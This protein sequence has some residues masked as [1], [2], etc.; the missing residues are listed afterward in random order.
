MIRL[1]EKQMPIRNSKFA[2]AVVLALVAYASLAAEMP[3]WANE[4]EQARI[5]L[6]YS[7]SLVIC[8]LCFVIGVYHLILGSDKKGER[9]SLIYG[10]SSILLAAYFAD[11]SLGHVIRIPL[12]VTGIAKSLLSCSMCLIL[13]FFLKHYE[14]R[15]PKAFI[16][17][18]PVACALAIVMMIANSSSMA[19]I[20]EYFTYSL[21]IVLGCIVWMVKIIAAQLRRGSR[22]ALPVSIGVLVGI[23]TGVH[24][25]IYQ[26]QGL[27]PALWLQG[28]GFFALYL[29]MFVGLA[30]ESVIMR[31]NLEEYSFEAESKRA[32]I[33]K[34]LIEMQ[35]IA[36]KAGR[37]GK[38][39]DEEISRVA[40]SAGRLNSSANAMRQSASAQTGAAEG[41]R[42]ELVKLLASF[43]QVFEGLGLQF[44]KIDET[45]ETIVR[46]LATVDDIDEALGRT[47]EISERLDADMEEGK[48][49]VEE[50]S[51]TIADMKG[52]SEETGEIA[53]TVSDFAKQTD[54]LAM[55][56]AIEAAH[57]GEAG[58]G[59]AVISDEIKRLA[60]AS[61]EKAAQIAV[62][63]A[64]IV[65]KI[66]QG[67]ATNSLVERSLLRSVEGARESLER[68]EA[69]AQAV[70]AQKE[71]SE[72]VM[73]YLKE[74]NEACEL[75]KAAAR[76]QKE[77]SGSM[78]GAVETIS[79]FLAAS[80]GDIER[81]GAE[82]EALFSSLRQLGSLAND[83]RS[84]TD[85]L[86]TLIKA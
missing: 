81:L 51:R 21:L 40:D 15:V 20:E 61:S 86:E 70:K 44:R 79:S 17:A 5:L 74:L 2:L 47:Q 66:D 59:F 49:R 33:A 8:V 28:I 10:V 46:M 56:A 83:T 4:P 65:G 6:S 12:P 7:L 55:N 36:E 30:M 45:T 75:I 18:A 3:D 27:E 11:F 29:S 54:I 32:K 1:G 23:G 57:A 72:A 84:V 62:F 77:S 69:A 14:D 68:I 43:D 82:I 26:V 41:S 85:Q 34:L 38:A 42:E 16:I 58:K 50:L 76:S 13:A 31:R 73:R 67:V 25:V 63:V 64:E 39:L 52:M 80:K 9:A 37:M 78:G 24:D 35:G 71:A 22:V 19:L 60:Q 48:E 53:S